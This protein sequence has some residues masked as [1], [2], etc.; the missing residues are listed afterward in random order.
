[1]VK[2]QD[3]STALE[4]NRATATTN[5][6]VKQVLLLILEKLHTL[7]KAMGRSCR[8]NKVFLELQD[9]LHDDGNGVNRLDN[10]TRLI[11]HMSTTT[12]I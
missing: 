9:A 3:D 7:K 8:Q 5:K 10:R 1:M 4:F 11:T 6:K 2:S 12:K